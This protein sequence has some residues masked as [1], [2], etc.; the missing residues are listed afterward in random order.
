MRSSLLGGLIGALRFNLNRK[1]SRVRLFEAGACFAKSGN[2]YVQTQRLSGIAYG[3]ISHEQWG[4]VSRPVDFY[5]VK[6]DLE[7]LFS[8]RELRL[9]A[10]VH[11]ALHPGR[12][13][14]ICFGDRVVGWIG[15]LHPQWQQQYDMVQAAVWFEVELESLV[16]AVVPRLNEISRFLP[17]RR[18]LAVLVDESVN[19]QALTDVMLQA[20]LAYVQEVVLFDVYRGRG[21]EQGKKS[22]AFR[23]SLQDTQ[24]TLTD[25]EIEPVI[26]QMVEVLNRQGAQL[27]M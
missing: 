16:E 20:Q 10:A 14:Q 25:A 13:A 11:P 1:Q 8:P 27:R 9:V 7:V 12:S 4:M 5:D 21:V 3:G 18:D 24:K 19:V 22:L 6:S 23:L 26:A 15:E 17:V 2:D